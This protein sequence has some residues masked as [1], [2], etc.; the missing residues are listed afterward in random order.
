MTAIDRMKIIFDNCNYNA[1]HII[2][3]LS[4]AVEVAAAMADIDRSR[5]HFR[6][7][8]NTYYIVI[9]SHLSQLQESE[10]FNNFKRN[11]TKVPFCYT[12]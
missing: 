9:H 12:L 3:P 10:T 7:I 1:H 8:S 11:A 6:S 2:L 4:L 5:V